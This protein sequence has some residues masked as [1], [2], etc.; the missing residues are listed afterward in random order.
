MKKFRLTMRTRSIME[1]YVFVFPYIIGLLAFFLFPLFISIKLSFG[2]LEKMVGF[3]I[4]WTGFQNYIR[5]FVIDTQFVPMFLNTAAEMGKK[6]PFIIVFSLLLAILINRDLKFKG[7]FRVVFFMPFL[8]GTGYVMQQ[9]LGQNV[10]QQVMSG[11]KIFFLPSDVLAYLGPGVG[12][13][14][15]SFFG[16]IVLVLWKSGVQ[17]L[18]FISGLQGIP[19][20]LYESAKMDSATEWEMFWHITLPMIS[21]IMLLNMVYTLVDSFMDVNNPILDY[22]HQTAFLWSQ[23]AYAAAIGWIYFAFILLLVLIVF[24]AMRKYIYISDMRGVTKNEKSFN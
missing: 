6:V 22:I 23:F 24:V 3:K 11:M 20:S 10:N 8:L 14:V 16:I 2:T 4:A 7:F 17:I 18:L 15:D 9:L 19:Q 1:G 12:N 21:P 13:A 5:A